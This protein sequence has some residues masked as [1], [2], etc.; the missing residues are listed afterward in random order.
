MRKDIAT[1]ELT[2]FKCTTEGEV[3][4]SILCDKCNAALAQVNPYT[5]HLELVR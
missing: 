3:L 4:S 1:R 5:V 2:L